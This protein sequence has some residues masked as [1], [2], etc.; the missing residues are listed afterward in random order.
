MS[1]IFDRLNSELEQFGRKAQ[2]ALDEGK[3]RLEFF[4]LRRE[5]DEAARELGRLVHRRDRGGE[6]DP[7]SIDGLMLKLDQLDAEITRVERAI[8]SVGGEAVSVADTPA[9]EG[10]STAEAKVE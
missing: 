8:A 10:A 2:A 4:R 7:A 9:P 1:G 6:V 5:Q 3:L